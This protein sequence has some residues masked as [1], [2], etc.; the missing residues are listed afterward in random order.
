V[1]GP[2]IADHYGGDVGWEL[3]YG[4]PGRV[5]IIDSVNGDIIKH[6]VGGK[7]FQYPIA[8]NSGFEWQ[9]LSLVIGVGH[10]G[11]NEDGQVLCLRHDN[12]CFCGMVYVQFTGILGAGDTGDECGV[13]I[14]DDANIKQYR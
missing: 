6:L 12:S 5:G 9:V 11:G 13:N 8:G 2:P 4:L 14:A 7:G 10:F 1:V 3:F